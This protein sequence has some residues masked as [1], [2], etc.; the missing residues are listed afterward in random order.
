MLQKHDNPQAPVLQLE[1]ILTFIIVPISPLP[2]LMMHYQSGFPS[3]SWWLKKPLDCPAGYRLI[4]PWH[5]MTNSLFVICLAEVV[6]H[7]VSHDNNAKVMVLAPTHPTTT[8]LLFIHPPTH[9]PV[10]TSI[11]PSVHQPSYPPTH[12]FIHPPIYSSSI[13]PPIHPLFQT[14]GHPSFYLFTYSSIYA[15]TYIPTHSTI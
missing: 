12:S 4:V 11:H 14:Q 13:Y 10:S 9:T 5:V 2:V 15:P 6:L 7:T 3:Y 8:P 1:G